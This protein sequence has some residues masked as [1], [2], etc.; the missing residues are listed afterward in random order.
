MKKTQQLLTEISTLLRQIE[1]E[2]PELYKYLDETP[3][4]IPDMENP[5]I[6]QNTLNEYL[7]SLKSMVDNYEKEH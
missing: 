6:D 2:H 4:T 3:M 1:E 5:D 7:E